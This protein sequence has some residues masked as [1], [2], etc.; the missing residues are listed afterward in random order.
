MLVL[1]KTRLTPYQKLAD[2]I[3]AAIERADE[4][5]ADTIRDL[6]PEWREAVD[7]INVALKEIT[8]CP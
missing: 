1:T 3:D 6:L 8:D 5:G 2:D 4:I 7:A